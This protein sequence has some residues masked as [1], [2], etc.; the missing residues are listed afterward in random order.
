LDASETPADSCLPVGTIDATHHPTHSLNYGCTDP[1]AANHEPFA[2]Y[3]D[4]SCTYMKGRGL[5]T[6]SWSFMKPEYQYDDWFPTG[7]LETDWN[8][9][10]CSAPNGYGFDGSY[11]SDCDST[12]CELHDLCPAGSYCGVAT[13]FAGVSASHWNIPSTSGSSSWRKMLVQDMSDEEDP[14]YFGASANTVK[15]NPD[16]TCFSILGEWERMRHPT[17]GIFHLKLCY[18]GTT[19][20]C[21]EWMQTCNPITTTCTSGEIGR[22]ARSEMP[23]DVLYNYLTP[24]NRRFASRYAPRSTPRSTPRSSPLTHRR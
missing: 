19:F 10:L 2:L 21:I 8:G 4:E 22:G 17:T 9:D 23:D 14:C 11:P 16:S 24:T 12:S 18:D 5:S 13:H 7:V 20:G 1:K 15:Y 6:Q 3:E